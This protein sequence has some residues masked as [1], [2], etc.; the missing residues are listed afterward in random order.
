MSVCVSGG[1]ESD[2]EHTKYV[3]RKNMCGCGETGGVRVRG[4]ERA[5]ERRR[6]RG[7]G[8][9]EKGERARGQEGERGRER[10]VG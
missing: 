2:K 9:E 3:E 6:E 8:R 10:D 5:G 4:N 1:N 7:E